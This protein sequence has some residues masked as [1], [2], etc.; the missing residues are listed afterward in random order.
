MAPWRRCQTRPGTG[1]L[2]ASWKWIMRCLVTSNSLWQAVPSKPRPGHTYPSSHHCTSVWWPTFWVLRNTVQKE[3][4]MCSRRYPDVMLCGSMN[5]PPLLCN[6]EWPLWRNTKRKREMRN[7][8]RCM[9]NALTAQFGRVHSKTPGS[10]NAVGRIQDTL[11]IV[12]GWLECV[13]CPLPSFQRGYPRCATRII[14]MRC[15]SKRLAFGRIGL[16][17][18]PFGWTMLCWCNKLKYTKKDFC[19]TLNLIARLCK[20][21][22][23][24]WTTLKQSLRKT[25]LNLYSRFYLSGQLLSSHPA[26]KQANSGSYVTKTLARFNFGSFGTFQFL[27]LPDT[28]LWK[29][30]SASGQ[31]FG[32]LLAAGDEERCVF[33]R[34]SE[35]P[36]AFLLLRN[37]CFSQLEESLIYLGT[38]KLILNP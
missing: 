16:R 28:R 31:N 29:F 36:L 35:P 19:R 25:L 2:I 18:F 27:Q 37:P 9:S 33:S 11:P 7:A 26:K 14:L 15:K 6:P 5:L 24:E 30:H 4:A 1:C 20:P 21:F 3:I 10:L 22:L 34:W 12:L 23:P 13:W 38:S 32:G 17:Q 8:V